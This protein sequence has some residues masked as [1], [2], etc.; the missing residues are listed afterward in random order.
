MG[1]KEYKLMAS[2]SLYPIAGRNVFAAGF[3]EVCGLEASQKLDLF[4][5]F[6][7]NAKKNK[8]HA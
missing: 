8:S 3:A 6:W 4:G 7:G 5:S 1:C 2:K